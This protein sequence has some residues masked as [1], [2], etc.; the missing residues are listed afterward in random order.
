LRKIVYDMSKRKR[1][2]VNATPTKVVNSV[3]EIP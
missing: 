1:E 2:S 3:D